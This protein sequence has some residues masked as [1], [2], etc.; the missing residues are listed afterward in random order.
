MKRDMNLIRLQLLEV[1]GEEPKPNLEQYTEEQQV[2][3]M[4]LSIEAGL[5]DGAIVKDS[6]GYPAA[7]AAI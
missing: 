7:T 6:N 1:E 5:V 4:A 2:Y 3:H